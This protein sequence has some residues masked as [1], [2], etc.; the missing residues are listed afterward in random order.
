[1]ALSAMVERGRIAFPR[2]VV[3]E[4]AEHDHPDATG[5]WIAHAA[6]SLH[7]SY[8][9]DD[10]VAHVVRQV[11]ELIDPSKSVDQADPYVLALALEIADMDANFEVIVVTKDKIKPC[12]A[13]LVEDGVRAPRCAMG[14][15][16]GTACL[17]C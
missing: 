17:D 11:P 7:Y 6:K 9:D 14:G 12:D 13:D 8:P 4:V 10:T 15:V 2:Q 3:R 5:A 1:M 16:A